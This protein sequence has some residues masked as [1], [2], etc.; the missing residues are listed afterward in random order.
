ME[1][2]GENNTA[3]SPYHGA[4]ASEIDWQNRIKLQSVVQKYTT[5][6]I[7]STLNL[8]ENVSMEQV[9]K[10][11][12]DAWK[13]GLKG[14]TVYRAG[15]RS[16]VLISADE[17]KSDK[18]DDSIVETKAP[19]RPRILEAEVV[20]FLNQNEKWI[21]VVG[22]LNGKPYEIFTGSAEDSFSLPQWVQ[23]GWVIKN[24]GEDGKKR[25]DFQY[26]DREGYKVTIEGL[27]RS[28]NK[29]YWNYAKLIS[30]VLRHGM[31]LP[32]VLNVVEHMHFTTD[33]INSW[34]TGVARALKKFVP[35]G[36]IAADRKCSFCGDPDGL[37]YEEG[38]L[39]CRSCGHSKCG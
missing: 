21:A 2:S 15:S 26:S 35:D 25:Y 28:F 34:K 3:Q 18:K 27:S 1:I 29:E 19:K 12:F 11:Y 39:K 37:Y 8:P 30:G 33:T 31:P 13:S 20:R 36:T 24:K 16:G 17:K 10:I 23:N 32:H 9:G 4:T 22:I 38:C 14:V 5:H 7:S 6:S